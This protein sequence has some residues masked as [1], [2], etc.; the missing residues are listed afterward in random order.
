MV[1]F[2]AGQLQCSRQR[3]DNLRRRRRG[4][5]LLKPHDIVDRDAGEIGQLLAAQTS[6]AAR[7]PRGQADLG[8]GQAVTPYAQRRG[9]AGFGSRHRSH[10]G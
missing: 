5:A 4:S 1:T 3:S 9:E 10:C 2:A 8:T 6:S 7:P